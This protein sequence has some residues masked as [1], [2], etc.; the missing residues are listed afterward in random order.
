MDPTVTASSRGRGGRGRGRGSG[1]REQDAAP[2]QG[3]CTKPGGR[4]RG[5]AGV[6]EPME[7]SQDTAESTNEGW[8]M[9]RD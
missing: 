7:V 3:G 9:G 5:W 6:S 2:S 4:G 1:T 8:R